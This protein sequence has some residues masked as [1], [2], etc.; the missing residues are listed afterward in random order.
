MKANAFGVLCLCF[1]SIYYLFKNVP[2]YYT[3]QVSHQ[4]QKHTSDVQS[5][6]A[7][8][9]LQARHNWAKQ[10]TFLALSEH[11]SLSNGSSA[12]LSYGHRDAFTL[13]MLT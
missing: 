11:I 4:L 6:L 12:A 3:R 10:K 8:R 5:D 7:P 2:Q 13:K 9:E 1:L